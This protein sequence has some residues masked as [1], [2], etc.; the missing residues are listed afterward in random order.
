MSGRGTPRGSPPPTQPRQPDPKAPRTQLPACGMG[1]GTPG[2]SPVVAVPSMAAAHGP[3]VVTPAPAQV[4]PPAA[5][6][7]R[8]GPDSCRGGAGGRVLA[9]MGCWL[10]RDAPGCPP[11]AP[12]SAHLCPQPLGAAGIRQGRG[13][14][15]W[16][17]AGKMGRAKKQPVSMETRGG[18]APRRRGGMGTVPR[19]PSSPPS[20]VPRGD[21]APVLLRGAQAA[22]TYRPRAQC[23]HSVPWHG[24][25]LGASQNVAGSGQGGQDEAPRR[26]W[27]G[28]PPRDPVSGAVFSSSVPSHLPAS[29]SPPKPGWQSQDGAGDPM[30]R[31][32]HGLS[33][34]P[35]AGTIPGLRKCG[36]HR[37][38]S[39]PKNRKCRPCPGSRS[40]GMHPGSGPPHAGGSSASPPPTSAGLRPDKLIA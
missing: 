35:R 26:C 12:P 34:C 1:M 18:P 9:P 36:S 17:T 5:L 2:V 10:P 14:G 6:G 31:G 33:G 13:S 37:D 27:G 23:A 22:G 40:Q 20:W 3:L 38:L 8:K 29:V 16:E 19:V 25:G 7:A 21:T 24:R 11:A 39:A 28:I 4:S 30:P 15:R 32:C